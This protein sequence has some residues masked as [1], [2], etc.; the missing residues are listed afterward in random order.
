MVARRRRDEMNNI[1]SNSNNDEDIQYGIRRSRRN[2]SWIYRDSSSL[3]PAQVMEQEVY[4]DTADTNLQMA[5][6]L[7]QCIAVISIFYQ[8]INGFICRMHTMGEGLQHALVQLRVLKTKL[9]NAM[10]HLLFLFG[11]IRCYGEMALLY[12]EDLTFFI[13]H[14]NRFNNPRF[15]KLDEIDRQICYGWFGHCPHDLR[16]LY[17]HWRVPN[18]LMALSSRHVFGGE[19]CFIIF[20]HH[21]MKANHLQKWHVKRLGGI[22]ETFQ[23]CSMQ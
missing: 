22:P 6:Q 13:R 4:Y 18:T 19:E 3:S 10:K 21:L 23:K 17:V 7:L 2:T 14:R 16:R 20:L 9:H 11:W 5:M 12:A 15:R 1:T 8:S